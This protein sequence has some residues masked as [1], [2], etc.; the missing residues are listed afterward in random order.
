MAED[1]PDAAPDDT[2]D[3][4]P[5]A[6]IVRRVVAGDADAFALLLDRHAE[7]VRRLVARNV[8]RAAVREVA[9]DA[10]VSAYLSLGT[11]A[12]THP[13]EHWLVR[14]ALRACAEYWRARGRGASS[15]DAATAGLRHD[16][17]A[18]LRADDRELCEW[19]LARLAREDREV[20]TLVYFE[21]LDVKECAK[22]LG[23]SASKVKVRAHRARVRLRRWLEDVLT[24]R[25]RP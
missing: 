24:R 22:L 5:D 15:V 3:D 21:E 16:D 20:L 13:F 1:E 25:E 14:V 6:A 7:R 11:Y 18:P 23:W 19:A 12:P 2:P 10:F 8:P 9:H 4:A 17:L